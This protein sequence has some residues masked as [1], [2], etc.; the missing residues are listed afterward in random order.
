MNYISTGFLLLVTG[1]AFISEA[2]EFSVK[3]I[4]ASVK[5]GDPKALAKY[6]LSYPEK[7]SAFLKGLERGDKDSVALFPDVLKG[8]ESLW[9]EELL[10]ALP[11]GLKNSPKEVL[12][13]MRVSQVKVPQL[14][15]FAKN[16][17]G[18]TAQDSNKSQDQQKLAKSAIKEL[19][20]RKKSILTVKDE[21]LADVKDEC[22]AGIEDTKKRWEKYLNESPNWLDQ[23]CSF[24]K[25]QVKQGPRELL[26]DFL[27][28]DFNGEFARN[29]PKFDVSISCPGHQGGSDLFEVVSGYKILKSDIKTD[30]AVFTVEFQRVGQINSAGPNGDLNTFKPNQTTETVKYN[31]I[32][33]PYGWRLKFDSNYIPNINKD[34]ISKLLLHPSWVEGEKAIFEKAIGK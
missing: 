4:P 3:D 8:T 21:S 20:V 22:I 25:T 27:A 34:K 10:M 14:E 24:V 11:N 16:N 17:C 1:F 6:I 33:T 5:N 7:N 28:R 32:K 18:N 29:S 12:E 23:S 15:N 19:N 9:T 30:T 2:K 13:A 31:A 26:N